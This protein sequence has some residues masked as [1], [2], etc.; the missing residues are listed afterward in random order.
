MSRTTPRAMPVRADEMAEGWPARDRRGGRDRRH[1][2]TR[3]WDSI[4]YPGRRIAGRRTGER[5]EVYVD[6]YGRR[7]VL[8]VV[9]I[10]LLN[11]VDALCTLAWLGRGGME[12]N[13]LM[14]WVL[15]AGAEFFLFQ[16]CVVAAVWLIILLVHKNFRIA[17]L[18]LWTLLGVYG[19]LALY[20]GLLML[21]AEP[22]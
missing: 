3:V 7:G 4:R 14:D 12:G 20:H 11:V 9:V 8:L 13:P 21:F 6:R 16:K 18:G 10:L 15:N 5:G 2:P 19:L 17:R 1:R 22:V